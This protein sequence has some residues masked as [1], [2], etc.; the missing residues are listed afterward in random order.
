MVAVDTN[1]VVRFLTQ[2]DPEQYQKSIHIFST[3]DIF[4]ADTVILEAEWVLRYAY[5]YQPTQII[6][7][8]KK[9]F[10]LPNVCLRDADMGALALAGQEAGLDFADALHLA[11]AVQCEQMLT[12]DQRFVNRASRL[13][14]IP[15]RLPD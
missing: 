13:S 5:D 8:F 7:A 12:F 15:V 3:Q 10:G 2:D 4:I 1:I 14:A 11:Q 9:L 6:A